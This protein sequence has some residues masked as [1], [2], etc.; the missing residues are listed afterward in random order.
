MTQSFEDCDW[1]VV[2]EGNKRALL[3]SIIS[4]RFEIT[5]II[6]LFY[7]TL[8]HTQTHTLH[9]YIYSLFFYLPCFYTYFFRKWTATY[10][11]ESAINVCVITLLIEG[12]DRPKSSLLHS[13]IFPVAKNV[14]VVNVVIMSISGAMAFLRS[15]HTGL[16][17]FWKLIPAM[18]GILAKSGL[19]LFCVN[20]WYF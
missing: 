14:N 15:V 6:F 13:C 12:C 20:P 19:T 11:S 10:S 2:Q 16:D 7:H 5:C 17:L 4:L 18:R 1:L 8:S 3:G 9:M